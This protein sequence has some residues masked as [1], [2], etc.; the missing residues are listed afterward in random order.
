MISNVMEAFLRPRRLLNV[1]VYLF[2]TAERGKTKRTARGPER[3]RQR[4]TERERDGGG[5][6]E[7]HR[8]GGD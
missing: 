1:L 6:R 4:D 8:E 3:E 5:G 7:T 2:M